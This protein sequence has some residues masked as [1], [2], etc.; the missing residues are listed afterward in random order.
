MSETQF[1]PFHELQIT[2]EGHVARVEFSRPQHN[3]FTLDLLVGLAE[4]FEHLDSLPQVRATILASAGKSFCAGADFNDAHA[5]DPQLPRRIYEAGL[6][7]FSLKKPMIAEI[8]GAA[9]GGGLGLALVADFRVAGDNARFVANFN[10]LGFHPGFGLSTT[11]PRLIGQ[12]QAAMLLYT[13]RRV[14]A[15]EA[16]RLGLADMHVGADELRAAA[17]A[18]A[19]DIALS[20]PLAVQSTRATLRT[21]LADAVR[22]ASLRESSEQEWQLKTEDFMEGVNAMTERRDPVFKGR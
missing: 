7:L 6:R 14:K 3:F 12:Q 17:M 8:Q 11:L 15:D 21:G 10:R 16:L 13:G 4:A 20:A 9:V 18:L 5:R 22:Q 2:Y 19:Q 1:L